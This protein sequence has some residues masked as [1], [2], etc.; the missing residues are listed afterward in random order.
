[1]FLETQTPATGGLVA[2]I[3][4]FVIMFAIVYFLMIRPQ[5]AQQKQRQAM[6]DALKKGDKVITIGGIHGEITALTDDTVILSIAD[7]TDIVISRS[8]VGSVKN[9]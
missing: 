2:L 3:L 4:P 9:G 6:L 8:G 5:Q 1:M 7:K